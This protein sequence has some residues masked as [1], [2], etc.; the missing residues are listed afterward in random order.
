MTERLAVCMH[1][2]L[3][4]TPA[5]QIKRKKKKKKHNVE[6]INLKRLRMAQRPHSCRSAAPV[7]TPQKLHPHKN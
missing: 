5:P 7:P 2:A 1:D 4:W 3:G 6:S